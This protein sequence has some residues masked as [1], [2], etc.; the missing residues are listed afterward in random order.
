[1]KYQ[2]F[3]IPAQNPKTAQEELNRF[4]DGC[5]VVNME[6]AFVANGDRSFWSVCVT[7]LEKEQG[8]QSSIKNRVDYREVLS[9]K[10][11]AIFVKLRNLRKSIAEQEGVPIY[12][13]FTNEQ[14]AVM[15]Q[16]KVLTPTAFGAIG[17]IGKMRLEKYGEAFLNVLRRELT[18]S[19]AVHP[20]GRLN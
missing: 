2:F 10:D 3:V 16:K 19:R 13:V 11:F 17:G 5:R 1:M 15:V 9:E 20:N 7:W 4:C 12:A 6:K 18:S 14:L 8:K